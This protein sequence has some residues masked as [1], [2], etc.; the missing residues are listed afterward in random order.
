M[1]IRVQPNA[2]KNEIVG[3]HGDSLKIKIAAVP[4]DGKANAELCAYV[5]RELGVPKSKVTV[6]KGQ[7]SRDKVI[8]V[9]GMAEPEIRAKLIPRS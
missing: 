3:E 6:I 7:T 9:E 2:R 1:K 4:E 8:A 5:A